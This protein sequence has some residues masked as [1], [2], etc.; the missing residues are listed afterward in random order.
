MVN[1]LE[2]YS[3]DHSVKES[4][5]LKKIQKYTYQN[6]KAPQM[7]TGAIVGNVLSLLIKSIQAK[8]I[9]EI[10]M[11]TGYSAMTMAQALPDNG[12]IH[13]C[14]IME[15]HVLTAQK[16][17]S[18]SAHN[19][20]IFVYTG[21]A[22]NTLESFK[23]NTFD[24]AFIDADKIN[25][26]EYYKRIITLIKTGGIIVLDNMLWSGEVI[27]PKDKQ[28]K[29]LN[30]TAQFIQNDSRVFNTLLPIRDGLMVCYKK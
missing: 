25:Y 9:L 13:T 19:D 18:Q 3:I 8:K 26:L 6:E 17:F 28:S 10:G 5:I 4:S 20:K 12:E 30:K 23:I 7:I 22:L 2:Q 15:E 16:F 24:L 11:F 14:E 21:K 27:D 1:D 29:V